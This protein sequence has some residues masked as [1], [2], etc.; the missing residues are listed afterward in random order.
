MFMFH[1]CQFC[2][3]KLAMYN[4]KFQSFYML[5]DFWD[6]RLEI[7]VVSTHVNLNGLS[8]HVKIGKWKIGQ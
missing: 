7:S 6:V 3:R 4:L 2:H 1:I 8:V 5:L